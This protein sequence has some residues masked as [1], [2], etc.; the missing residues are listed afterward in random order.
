MAVPIPSYD[1]GQGRS[2]TGQ[3]SYPWFPAQ[4]RQASV[5]WHQTGIRVRWRSACVKEEHPG[6]PI[7]LRGVNSI[8]SLFQNER[9]KKKNGAATAHINLAEKVFAARMRREALN[10]AQYVLITVF[11]F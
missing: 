5:L 1:A 6:I 2:C 9:R 11:N 3:C 7:I 4:D 10:H 8:L